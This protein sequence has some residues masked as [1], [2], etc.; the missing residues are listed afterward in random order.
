M[1]NQHRQHSTKNDLRDDECVF[2]R[3]RITLLNEK[4]WLYLW[5]RYQM[6]PR[7]LQVAKL[8]CR[9]FNNGEVVNILKIKNG[10][11]KTHL[12]NIY[13]K[14]RVKNK[15]GMLLRFMDDSAKFST[16]SGFTPSI[17]IVEVKK[18]GEEIAAPSR[19]VQKD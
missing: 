14:I 11:V 2:E 5:R 16:K 17:P 18:P 12:R 7:E 6:T 1:M 8:L 10:T 9:G 19:T 15:I 13:R 3:P 4:Q